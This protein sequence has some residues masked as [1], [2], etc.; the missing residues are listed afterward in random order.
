MIRW[1]DEQ[2]KAAGI[3]RTR[4]TTLLG[5][6]D[7][8]HK[9]MGRLGLSVYAESGCCYL[10]H[11]SRPEHTPRGGADHGAIVADGPVGRFDGGAW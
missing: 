10:I 2:L 3:D 1:T 9:L 4:L 5:H 6:L 7:N 8:A 11:D